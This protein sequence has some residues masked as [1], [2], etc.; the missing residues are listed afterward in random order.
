MTSIG[1]SQSEGIFRELRLKD[2]IIPS[3][4]I[5]RYLKDMVGGGE[6]V[7]PRRRKL[8]NS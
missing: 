7:E 6:N 2:K 1:D 8:Y 4:T 3:R 5:S